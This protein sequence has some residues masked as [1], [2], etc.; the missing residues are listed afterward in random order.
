MKPVYF[1]KPSFN[2]LARKRVSPDYAGTCGQALS[3]G[4]FNL[5]LSALKDLESSCIRVSFGGLNMSRSFPLVA[6]PMHEVTEFTEPHVSQQGLSYSLICLTPCRRPATVVRQPHAEPN[7]EQQPWPRQPLTKQRAPVY[8]ILSQFLPFICPLTL[9]PPAYT[10]CASRSPN[11]PSTKMQFQSTAILPTSTT[12][13]S[14]LITTNTTG[15]S[16]SIAANQPLKK[17]GVSVDTKT[18]NFSARTAI[19][20]LSS[21]ELLL[22]S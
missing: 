20:S 16:H 10:F 7:H 4:P 12:P 13:L 17:S 2:L 11:T 6:V 14:F 19:P 15:M 5:D 9:A 22:G 3:N 21:M 8:D 18:R 1:A